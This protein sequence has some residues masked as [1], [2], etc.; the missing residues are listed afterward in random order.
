MIQIVV[1]PAGAAPPAAIAPTAGADDVFCSGNNIGIYND[2]WLT[3]SMTVVARVP[4]GVHTVGVT[5]N[6]VNGATFLRLDDLSIT[7]DN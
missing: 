6:T 5:A 2:G 1:D 3:P 4:A 7:V